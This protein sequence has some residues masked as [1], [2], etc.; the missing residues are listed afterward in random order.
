MRILIVGAG[1]LGGYFGARLI[2][3]GRDV[4]FLVRAGRA[5]ELK[6]SGLVVKSTHGNATLRDVPTVLADGI[7]GPYDLVLLS[8]KAY[9]L[10][11]AIESFAPAVGPSTMILPVLNGMS[12][13][14]TL[15]A[16]FG[17]ANVLGGIAFI[18]ATL[19]RN[20][21]IE[22]LN[23]SHSIAY[24][25]LAGGMSDRIRE[26]ERTFDGANFISQ[27]V[28]NVGQRM[29]D[30]WTFLATLAASTCVT[31]AAIGDILKTRD[32]KQLIEG[33]YGECLGIAQ[34]NGFPVSDAV[35]TRDRG[36]LLKEG[37]P[38]TAS[39]LRDIENRSKIEADH[40]VG[41]L[42]ERGGEAQRAASPLSLLR[43][44]YT[45]LKAYEARETRG[46]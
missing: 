13:I 5:E 29:W 22:H 1:A 8:C 42:I 39:M 25:E 6:R 44:A 41:N 27:A 21:E 4:T 11:D 17:A 15:K 40:I 32:G 35:Q 28:D 16:K 10:D 23:D 7:R 26:I 31:R 43:V 12:H 30:K 2:E 18:A 19:N 46:G 36:V 9:N 38:L 37:S 24:G 33:I 14:D 3:A 20:R 34:H 45:H